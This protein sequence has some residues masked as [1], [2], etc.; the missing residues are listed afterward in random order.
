MIGQKGIFDGSSDLTA[1]IFHADSSLYYNNGPQIGDIDGDFISNYF[2]QII[3]TSDDGSTVFRVNGTNR[4]D[5]TMERPLMN[6]FTIGSRGNGSESANFN[7]VEL[8][9]YNRSLTLTEMQEIETYAN[10]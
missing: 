3:N 7:M 9:V 6:G 2:I 10:V 4:V 1:Y 5:G 8:L